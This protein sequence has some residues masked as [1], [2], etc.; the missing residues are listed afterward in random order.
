MA[1]GAHDGAGA[2]A[3]GMY[4]RAFRYIIERADSALV[5]NDS[6][7]PTIASKWL[8]RRPMPR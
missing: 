5:A 2:I 8:E 6:L 4:K 3:D 1:P 7:D